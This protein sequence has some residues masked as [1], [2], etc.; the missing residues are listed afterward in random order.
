[1]IDLDHN[2]A[3]GI[4]ALSRILGGTGANFSIGNADV[5]AQGSIRDLGRWPNAIGLHAGHHL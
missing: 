4:V 5:V 3:N 2:A 1:M